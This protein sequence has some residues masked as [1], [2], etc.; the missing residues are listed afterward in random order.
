ML[1]D[2]AVRLDGEPV[3]IRSVKALA[4]LVFLAETGSPHP[5]SALAGLLWPD[6]DEAAARN[7][8]RQALTALRK[9]IG[10]HI[11]VAGDRVLLAGDVGTDTRPLVAERCRG[12][13]LHHFRV[14][15][16]DL[17][18]EW[19]ART[20][21][22][23]E[24]V[25][26]SLLTREAERCLNEG[27]TID[28]L[29][30]AHRVLDVEPWNEAA[31][32]LIMRLLA[33]EGRTHEA[34][35]Q[36]D[37]C[38][39]LLWEHLGIQPDP[40]T[41]QTLQEIERGD[42][43]RRQVAAPATSFHGRGQEI[44]RIGGLIASGSRRLVTLVG[45]GGIGKTRLALAIA[46]RVTSDRHDVPIVVGLEGVDD[47]D[48][49][50]PS[51]AAA[52]SISLDGGGTA[53]L[54]RRLAGRRGLMV[55]DNA[56]QVA[57]AVADLCSAIVS[58]VP[59]MSL[60][61]TSRSVLG[62]ASEWVEWLDGLDLEPRDGGSIAANLFVDRARRVTR[63]IEP[64][65]HVEELCGLLDGLPLAIELAAGLA[66][67]QTPAQIVELLR[68]GPDALTTDLPDVSVRHRSISS[69]L[70]EALA[71]VSAE[72]ADL[73]CRLSVFRGG[74]DRPAALVVA[75]GDASMLERLAAHSL[76]V[77]RDGD[78]YEMHELVRRHAAA[79]LDASGGAE[80]I[81]DVHMRHHLAVLTE[82][83]PRL[84]RADAAPFRDALLLDL[85]NITVA[86]E[87]AIAR[88]D[89]SLLQHAAAAIAQLGTITGR[90]GEMAAMLE[91]AA[92]AVTG[93]A[94]AELIAQLLHL[95][96]ANDDLDSSAERYRRGLDALAPNG[97]TAADLS[98]RVMLATGY[99]QA[100]SEIGG[101]TRL[102]ATLL[103]TARTS[104][105]GSDEPE[106][107]A[108]VRVATAK[109]ETTSGRFDAAFA[110]LE[111]ALAYYRSSGNVTGEAL[112]TSRLAM[113]Y[114]EQYRVGPAL[115]ADLEALRLYTLTGD[116]YRIDA[117]V[118]NVGASY[119]LCGAWEEAEW[120]T[121]QAL[122][123][124][125]EIGDWMLQ[126]YIRCQLAEVHAGRGDFD[127]AERWFLEGIRGVRDAG[128]SLSLRLKLPEWAR[129]LTNTGRHV[130]ALSAAA[131][132]T[133][134]WESIGGEHFGITVRAI[135]ARALAG[136][137]CFAEASELAR[138][139]SEAI[140]RRHA[141]MLPYPIESIVDC[142]IALGPAEAAVPA[143]L[144]L[145]CRVVEGVVGE[146][147][148]P[149]LQASFLDL[150]DVRYVTQ[151][152]QRL[153]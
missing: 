111:P 151:H 80:Q 129:F 1:G 11:A 46:D 146:I 102:A 55:I 121:R 24:V 41:T 117:C 124:A 131:E 93:L 44:D 149:R 133:A 130:Q 71:S 106:L 107:D 20:R 38:A 96:W 52:C 53:E 136:T 86:W 77:A 101:D 109:N 73:L 118:I 148:D 153:G 127:E 108:Y 18:E 17:F 36:Y 150:V 97:S 57:A 81:R 139:V 25:A 48:R 66:G 145:G 147:T 26:I 2:L 13:F 87:R 105:V 64:D 49:V 6:R 34:V 59:G 3:E 70:D 132:A 110:L 16:S 112:V 134:V 92:D 7:N 21:A 91:H 12:P 54:A 19:A 61:V 42:T 76:L 103:E 115:A 113:A 29:T 126:P 51:V 138:D 8:L 125:E 28:G 75:A 123:R 47:P 58:A 83:E 152:H 104:L 9:E 128:V 4:L 84:H 78:R 22:A 45:P 60:L 10:E 30:L 14:P 94:R 5:R 122:A 31:H 119:V 67:R 35:E 79:R 144:E 65:E 62:L 33:S 95:A 114:A 82:A 90:T 140:L 27:R 56:E 135:T 85:D 43:P 142:A 37:R 32:R 100:V 88:R 98:A 40:A 63:R 120:Y 69:I 137:G 23:H 99:A 89:A 15:D 50:L 39:D 74:F 116:Q 141:R 72:L 143:L 68:H